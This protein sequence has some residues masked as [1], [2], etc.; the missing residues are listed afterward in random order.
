MKRPPAALALVVAALLAAGSAVPVVSGAPPSFDPAP[1]PQAKDKKEAGKPAPIPFEAL[2]KAFLDAHCKPSATGP[3][4]F[5]S[6]RTEHYVHGVLGLFDCAYPAAAL[7][8][9]PRVDELRA[10]LDGLLALQSKWIG[11][12]A[13]G[14]VSA[15]QADVALLRKW[16]AGAKPAPLQK[17]KAAPDKDLFALL[18]ATPEQRAASQRLT[19]LLTK[20]EVLGVAPTKPGPTRLIFA[21]KRRDFVE[22]AGYAGLLDPAQRPALWVPDMATWTSFWL[23]WD[24]VLALEYPAWNDDPGFDKGVSMN[25]YDAT[26]VVQHAVQQA[27]Q[28]LLW[29]CYGESDAMHLQQAFALNMAI[30]V[31][32]EGNVL[33][34]DAGHKTSGGATA[35]YERF[36]PGGSSSGGTLPAIPAG[37]QDTLSTSPWRAGRGADHFVEPL[38]NGQKLAM[39]QMIKD[40]PEKMDPVLG[41]DRTAHFLLTAED[42]IARRIVSA[43]FFGKLASAKPYPPFEFLVDYREFFRVYRTAFFHWLRSAGD[44]AG[45][46]ESAAKCATLM[47]ELATREADKS[48][49]ALVE[50]VYGLPLTGANSETDSLEWRFLEWVAKGR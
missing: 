41:R 35:P 5:D 50:E 23:G 19:E 3:C 10:I 14:D 15:A 29:R 36:V 4:A 37:S 48:F 24:L 7:E 42:G 33:E 45:A 44:P 22:L 38:R 28:A 46:E 25:K 32:G 20:K 6:I 16:L 9:K 43:P 11:W 1:A 8:E 17:A 39:K 2:G 31:C 30:E 18:G 13:Q 47:R 34:G 40:R 21:P 49:E 26:G 27:T 12:L